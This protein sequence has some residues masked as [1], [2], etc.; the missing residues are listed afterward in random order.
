MSLRYQQHESLRRT[1]ELLYDMLFTQT[2]PKTV[3]EMKQRVMRCLRHFPPLTEAGQP[4]FSNDPW[5][6]DK[7]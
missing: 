3:K 7:R 5:S 4:I 1:R 6:D 2:R